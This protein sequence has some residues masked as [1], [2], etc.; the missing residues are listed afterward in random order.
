MYLFNF[1]LLFGKIASNC[2]CVALPLGLPFLAPF[3]PKSS[4]MIELTENPPKIQTY[5]ED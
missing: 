2:L 4:F 3:A 1:F 5:L